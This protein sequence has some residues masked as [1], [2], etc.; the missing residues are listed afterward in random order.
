MTMQPAFNLMGT[1][2]LT[3]TP[4]D[5]ITFGIFLPDKLLFNSILLYI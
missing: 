3:K 2:M 4:T 1:V 5:F